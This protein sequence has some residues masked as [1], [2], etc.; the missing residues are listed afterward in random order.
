LLSGIG[1]MLVPKRSPDL[2]RDVNRLAETF[3][4]MIT[5]NLKWKRSNEPGTE[6]I[7]HHYYSVLFG[8][9]KI[10]FFDGMRDRKFSYYLIIKF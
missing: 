8:Q 1:K 6:V 3:G 9:M 2:R 5:E 10:L 7:R 4:E